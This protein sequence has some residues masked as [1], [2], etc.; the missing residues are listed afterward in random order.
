MVGP[1]EP[2]GGASDLA[3]G[4]RRILI[5][6][7]TICRGKT[8]SGAISGSLPCFSMLISPGDFFW[9]EMEAGVPVVQE[10]MRALELKIPP[11]ALVIITATLMWLVSRMQLEVLFNHGCT[12]IDTDADSD[13]RAAFDPPNR[14]SSPTLFASS[15]LWNPCASV[16]IRGSILHGSLQATTAN[17]RRSGVNAAPLLQ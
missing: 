8:G 7:R 15:A 10:P 5:Q 9:L 2:P 13:G 4:V 17:G 11:V 1:G 14:E 12:R 16:F 3:Q 6:V